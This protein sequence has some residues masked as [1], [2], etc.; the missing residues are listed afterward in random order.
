MLLGH[1]DLVDRHTVRGWAADTDRPY[2]TLEVAVFVDGRLMG[3]ARADQARDDL[4]DPATL[5]AGVHGL[6]YHFDPPLAL[7]QDHEV[8]VRF[9]EGGR[10]LGQWRVAREPEEPS[11]PTQ[12]TPPVK[13]EAGAPPAAAEEVV[14]PRADHEPASPGDGAPIA[15][16]PDDGHRVRKAATGSGAL[17]GQIL[18]GFVDQF[19]SEVVEGWA[20]SETN[21]NEILDISIFIDDRKVAQITCDQP[22]GD[23]AKARTYGDGAR[24]FIYVFN[25]PLPED[26]ETRVTVVFSC[27]GLPLFKGDVRF[28]NGK[29]QRLEGPAPL[30]EDEPRL[31]APPST[32]RAL[33]EFLGLYDEQGGLAQLLSRVE[34]GH[35]RPEQI[36][37]AVFG[38]QPK[39]V[40]DVLRWGTYYPRDHLQDLLLSDAFQTELIPLVLRAFPEKRRLIFVHIPKCAGTDLTFHFRARYPSMDRSLADAEWTSKPNM[41]RRIARVVAHLR[42]SDSIFVHGHINL[43]DHIAAN[44]IRPTDHAFTIVRDPLAAAMSQINYVLTRFDEDIAAG[45]LRPDTAEWTRIMDLGA[46]PAR[47]TDSF[48][49]R[50]TRAALRNEDLVLPNTLCQWLGAEGA[51]PV[52]DRLASY[53]VEVTDVERYNEW[54]RASWGIDAST[55]WNAS[56]PFIALRDLATDDVAYL[57]SIT[58]EDQRFYQ[59]V[60][61]ILSA[62]GKLSLTGDDLRGVVA[63]RS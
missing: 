19:T 5:G 10:L 32:P 48:I 23:L 28:V 42:T 6:A 59:T 54:L 30:A 38:A 15:R 51:Q 41:L 39:S 31:L 35:A 1:I 4:K 21:P 58:R 63:T 36:H 33:F 3:L 49:K 26:R 16:T 43:R 50:V 57:N 60:E 8:V 61:R 17:P 2:G 11:K 44:V 56:K 53:N 29:V 46:T 47:M 52:V 12:A 25:P 18:A 13:P 62:S 34:F 37:H 40:D 14:A 22:R 9:A 45:K 7:Q 55:R 27:T 24:G 20:A